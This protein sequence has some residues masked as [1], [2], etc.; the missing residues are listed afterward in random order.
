MSYGVRILF[1][2]QIEPLPSKRMESSFADLR[3]A[4]DAGTAEVLSY[5]LRSIEAAF[6][7]LDANGQ[8]VEVTAKQ[9]DS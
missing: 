6:Q 4:W 9:V 1:L 8:I 5:Q 7:V 3:E 2:N